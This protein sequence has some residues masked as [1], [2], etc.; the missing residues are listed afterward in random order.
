MKAEIFIFNILKT[1]NQIISLAK[2]SYLSWYVI[3]KTCKCGIPKK[4]K[5]KLIILFFLF[6]FKDGKN[7]ILEMKA[8]LGCLPRDL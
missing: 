2:I 8:H 7:K 3:S 4:K 6:F 1:K 5:K